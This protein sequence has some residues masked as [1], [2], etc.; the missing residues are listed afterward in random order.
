MDELNVKPKNWTDLVDGTPFK[1]SDLITLQDPAAPR[2]DIDLAEPG[3]VA[4]GEDRIAGQ[5]QTPDRAPFGAVSQPMCLLARFE[6]HDEPWR[7]S[8][9]ARA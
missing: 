4:P 3:P 5:A 8:S 7:F 1:R 2:D 9:S 6:R